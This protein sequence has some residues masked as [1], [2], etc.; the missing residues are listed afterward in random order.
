[1]NFELNRGLGGRAKSFGMAARVQGHRR[2]PGRVCGRLRRDRGRERRYTDTTN[3][4][5]RLFGSFVL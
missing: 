3:R 4:K 5:L 1:M 2:R